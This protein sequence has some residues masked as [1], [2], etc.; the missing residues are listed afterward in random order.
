MCLRKWLY[1]Q[2]RCPVCHTI[3]MPASDDDIKP[4][5]RT[6]QPR[7]VANDNPV[8]NENNIG[9]GPHNVNVANENGVA[10]DNRVAND[11]GVAN[12]NTVSDG[13]EQDLSVANGS[14]TVANGNNASDTRL[15]A[16]V[17]VNDVSDS[18]DENTFHNAIDGTYAVHAH[19]D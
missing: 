16:A 10:N 17:V 14:S 5:E 7:H 19:R 11:I 6:Q 3:V 8:A 13:Q 2:E 4:D 12:D 1:V 18:D 15:R 9:D